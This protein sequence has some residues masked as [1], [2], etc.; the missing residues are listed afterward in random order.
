MPLVN[1]TLQLTGADSMELVAAAGLVGT[2]CQQIFPGLCVA[3][4]L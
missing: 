1:E 3:A 4:E 2:A